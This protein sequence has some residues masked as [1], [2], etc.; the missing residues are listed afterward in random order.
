M[1]EIILSSA[2]II[3][4]IYMYIQLKQHS[5]QIKNLENKYK[6]N[7][8]NVIYNHMMSMLKFEDTQQ[9]DDPIFEWKKNKSDKINH[10]WLHHLFTDSKINRS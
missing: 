2:I 8:K 3:L 1:L 7:D 4:G 5:D 9:V 10:S 6:L